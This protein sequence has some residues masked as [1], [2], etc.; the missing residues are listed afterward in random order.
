L[1]DCLQA[2]LRVCYE[3]MP[4][5]S[6]RTAFARWLDTRI[7]ELGMSQADVA[8]Y[9]GTDGVQ[10]MR[11]R[12]GDAVPQPRFLAKLAQ[13]FGMDLDELQR[14]AYLPAS[15]NLPATEQED[16]ER[17]RWRARHEYLLEQKVPRPMWT[18]YLKACEALA[19]VFS[20]NSPS[21]LNNGSKGTFSQDAD[22]ND[23][24]DSAGNNGPLTTAYR[25][26]APT[27]RSNSLSPLPAATA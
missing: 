24:G 2:G 25:R 5:D 23:E 3:T 14:L 22:K 8:R 20:Q 19:E 18:A 21:E 11:W 17:L 6:A 12:R 27:Y 4:K 10:V 16:V 1:Q 9:V 15:S 13:L 26:P 7:N